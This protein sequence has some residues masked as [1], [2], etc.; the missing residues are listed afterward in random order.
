[1]NKHIIPGTN[2]KRE[3]EKTIEY[4]LRILQFRKSDI[5]KLN[6]KE[7]SFAERN[8][9]VD[10]HSINQ[11]ELFEYSS[12]RQI[13]YRGIINIP[14]AIILSVM[15]ILMFAEFITNFE[16]VIVCIICS[17]VIC[18]LCRLKDI[19]FS[20]N[21]ED[22]DVCIMPVYQTYVVN[23]KSDNN[24]HNTIYYADAFYGYEKIQFQI[25]TNDIIGFKNITDIMIVNVGFISEYIPVTIEEHKYRNISEERNTEGKSIGIGL[26]I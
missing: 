12:K 11:D 5:P 21:I 22:A 10:W 17:C 24:E 2:K 4:I 3:N 13:H 1:M 26:N 25:H 16:G 15:S 18:V 14:A 9:N 20:R 19:Y 23:V 6:F 7:A 8:F